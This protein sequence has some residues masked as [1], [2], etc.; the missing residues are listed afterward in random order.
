MTSTHRTPVTTVPPPVVELHG[1]IGT[2]LAQYA[3]E[4]VMQALDHGVHPLG[5]ARI[6]V[7]RHDDPARV[8][9][10]VASAHDHS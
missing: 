10:I 7:V 6:R 1:V 9:P 5:P 3:R 4:K 2:G 8:R